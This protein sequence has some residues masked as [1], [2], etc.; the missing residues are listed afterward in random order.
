MSALPVVVT[1]SA[2][3]AIGEAAEWWSRNRTAAPTALTDEI[4]RAFALIAAHPAVG[5]RALNTTLTDVRRVH[6]ARVRYYLYY[7]VSP[8]GDRIEVLAFWHTSRGSTPELPT[9]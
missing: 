8:T 1:A 6:L 4:E 9:R 5:A 2:A 7:R 3:T